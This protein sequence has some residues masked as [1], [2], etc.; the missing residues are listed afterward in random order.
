MF[1]TY[2]EFNGLTSPIYINR[3][4]H[5]ELKILAKMQFGVICA[6]MIDFCNPAHISIVTVCYNGN[7]QIST[8]VHSSKN[9]CVIVCPCVAMHFVVLDM[10]VTCMF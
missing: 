5:L 8:Y 4:L 7:R 9:T 10:S 1:F 2:A 6:H 3:I